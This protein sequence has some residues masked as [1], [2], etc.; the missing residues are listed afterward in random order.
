MT[1]PGVLIPPSTAKSDGLG[2]NNGKVKEKR[3]LDAKYEIFLETIEMQ[4]RWREK[5]DQ[6]AA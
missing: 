5:M 3:I 6:A 4:K 2:V 1:P